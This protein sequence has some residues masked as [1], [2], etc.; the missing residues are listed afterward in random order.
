MI[1]LSLAELAFVAIGMAMLG[2]LFFGW[3]SRWSAKNAELRSLRHRIVC[4]LCLAVFEESG[5]QPVV[6]CPECKAKTN[7][8]GPQALG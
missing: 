7:R 6:E 3:V 4:R 2:V 8:G 1:Y 5:R